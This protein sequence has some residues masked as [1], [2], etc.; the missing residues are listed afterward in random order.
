MQHKD[1]KI[2]VIAVFI[3]SLLSGYH[4]HIWRY[5]QR[6]MHKRSIAVQCFCIGIFDQHS[7]FLHERNRTFDLAKFAGPDAGIVFSN[8]I[9]NKIGEQQSI[10][11]ISKELHIPLVSV[12]AECRGVPSVLLDNSSGVNG[13]IEHAVAVH[14]YKNILAIYGPELNSDA[15]ERKQNI[16]SI[17]EQYDIHDG[18]GL[19]SVVWDYSDIRAS[20]NRV[21]EIISAEGDVDAVLAFDDEV[22]VHIA[23]AMDTA[24]IESIRRP[25]LFGF[26]NL[27][28]YLRI[29]P[30]LT[31][32]NQPLDQLVKK[33]IDICLDLVN[34]KQTPA[35]T[36]IPTSLVIRTS[37]GC[38]H[39]DNSAINTDKNG[40]QPL[41]KKIRAFFHSE[42][43]DRMPAEWQKLAA[44]LFFDALFKDLVSGT[45][46]DLSISVFKDL[47]AET[48]ASG[49]EWDSWL[50]FIDVIEGFLG[51]HAFSRTQEIRKTD[52]IYKMRDV[53]DHFYDYLRINI[54]ETKAGISIERKYI[55]DGF[56]TARSYNE[57]ADNLSRRLLQLS[58]PS[59]MLLLIDNVSWPEKG[60]MLISADSRSQELYSISH[61]S[62]IP[63]IVFSDFF[64]NAGHA[65][66]VLAM[67]LYHRDTFFG[68]AFLEAGNRDSSFYEAVCSQTSHVINS[69]RQF[70][71]I[72]KHSETLEEKVV[73]RIESLNRAMK[74][75]E[76]AYTQLKGIDQIKNDFIMNITHDF[77]SPLTVINNLAELSL[78]DGEG[79]DPDIR[80][81]FELIQ[82]SGIQLKKYI[83]QLL[84]LSRI[85]ARG[86]KLNV[87]A[88][89]LNSFI[90]KLSAFYS[91][92]VSG[93]N[94]S[95]DCVVPEQEICI[96]SDAAKLEDILHNIVSNAVKFVHNDRGQIR[97]T[98]SESDDKVLVSVRDNGA[99]IEKK[100][101][102]LIFNRFE[103]IESGGVAKQRSTGIGLAYAIQLAGLLQGK[104]W[105]ESDGIGKGAEF[106]LELPKGSEYFVRELM[107]FSRREIEVNREIEKILRY[108]ILRK[109]NE[110]KEQKIILIDQRNS[111]NEYDS[112]KGVILIV[113]DDIHIR[114]II[115]EYLLHEGYMNYLLASNGREAV[116]LFDEYS[117]D[118]VISDLNMP[119]M[120]GDELYDILEKKNRAVIIPF[121]FLSAVGDQN[122]SV[123]QRQ[124][125]AH[126]CLKKPIDR[127]ELLAAVSTSLGSC[128][129]NK[130][131]ETGRN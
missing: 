22:A 45:H 17:L 32:V 115:H 81:N 116:E 40:F 10:E 5:L 50:D 66:P 71:E 93:S 101:L 1:R 42:F 2:P 121:I 19:E 70:T 127:R 123:R 44:A 87:D 52:L 83:D 79:L 36:R 41:Q 12:G 43:R 24:G 82:T 33:S 110:N 85:D 55:S 129:K 96:H 118:L 69:L 15:N 53:L 84:E 100:H 97:I 73:E 57:L 94:I 95:I 108:D 126:A 106:F 6:E 102:K 111:E 20:R 29:M 46:S 49:M 125:G 4:Q 90:R 88:I 56:L 128:F 131:R 23:D 62:R 60:Y 78:M 13:I 99:G 76:T 51:K 124:K 3:D 63:G 21:I 98:L 7:D 114:K 80:E 35:V 58:T 107:D 77:R 92:S 31:T 105:A 89:E 117:P 112:K 26:N 47:L 68:Y 65:S 25:A 104:I 119:V 9:G 37:C 103:K 75:L 113:E 74:E 18:N 64:E 120:G 34:E 38:G 91:S 54:D 39:W 130:Q 16:I 8:L 48:A 28:E 27:P 122:S 61:L 30:G 11:R 14:G 72:R 67:A 86:I 109:E 59:F